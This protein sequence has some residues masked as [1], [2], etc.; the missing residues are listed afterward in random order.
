MYT[1]EHDSGSWVG[2]H[3]SRL[4]RHGL[5]LLMMV[6]GFLLE[7][8]EGRK[9]LSRGLRGE[10]IGKVESIVRCDD[11]DVIRCRCRCSVIRRR[12]VPCAERAVRAT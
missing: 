9:T 4:E 2:S 12:V 8:E 1:C 5:V 3:C 10:I 11:D 7:E 6:L